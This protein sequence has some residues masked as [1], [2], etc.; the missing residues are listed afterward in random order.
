MCI[1]VFPKRR[2]II[3][4]RRPGHYR[5]QS[6]YR[7]TT[8]CRPDCRIQYIHIKQNTRHNFVDIRTLWSVCRSF[9]CVSFMNILFCSKRRN[10]RAAL[11][12][13]LTITF[14]HFSTSCAHFIFKCKTLPKRYWYIDWWPYPRS[15]GHTI[16]QGE[17]AGEWTPES[18]KKLLKF[19]RAECEVFCDFENCQ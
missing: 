5:A 1:P 7:G 6:G 16:E 11:A 12:R 8:R 13:P 4:N 17:R 15:H 19:Q 2:N 9:V 18:K 14:A 3:F 10:V